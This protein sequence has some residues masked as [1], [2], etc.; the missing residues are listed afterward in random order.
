MYLPR[1][2]HECP[3]PS[4]PCSS[5]VEGNC[6][7]EPSPSRMGLQVVPARLCLLPAWMP[8]VGSG[9]GAAAMEGG[10]RAR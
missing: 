5:T 2:Q 3:K 9:V 4:T 6:C 10:G 7:Q 1:T 8:G